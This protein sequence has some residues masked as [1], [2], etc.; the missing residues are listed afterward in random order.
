MQAKGAQL[1][2]SHAKR[3]AH[4]RLSGAAAATSRAGS[5]S[6]AAGSS[7]LKGQTRSTKSI[8]VATAPPVW[9]AEFMNN[10]GVMPTEQQAVAQA[11]RFGI[12]VANA[13]MYRSYVSQMRAANPHLRM[14]VYLNGTFSMGGNP[15]VYPDS[16]YARDAAGNKITS[17]QFGNYL[18]DVSNPAWTQ[19][20]VTRCKSL[21]AA[22]HY[23]D[24]CFLDTMG[25]AP[26]VA[27]YVS[28]LPIVPATGKVWANSAW[29]A[30]TARIGQAVGK[31]IGN[32]H[33]IG[34]GVATGTRYFAPDGGATSAVLS[35]MAGSMVELFLRAPTTPVGTYES[36]AQWLEEIQMLRDSAAHGKQLFTMTKVWCS[37]TQRQKDSWNRFALSSFLLGYT[38]GLDWFSF[39]YDH[40]ATFDNDYWNAKVGVPAAPYA[41]SGG[42]YL[43]RFTNGLVVVN[44]G[45]G[46]VRLKLNGTYRTL[47]GAKISGTITLV[48][49]SGEVLINA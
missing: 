36:P 46:T 38:P 11:K 39:R 33:T 19:D 49:H 21:L 23:G 10:S 28:G 13:G 35:G 48:A 5:K 37:A 24:G 15:S 12:I 18:M 17:L 27:G 29:L 20:V 8:T 14:Y 4:H 7:S 45:A 30:A 2:P 32:S 3:A 47:E 25:T 6:A 9:G 31:A 16:W 26:L 41:K 44:P 34:N 1:M 42:S 22:S 43:R 40:G